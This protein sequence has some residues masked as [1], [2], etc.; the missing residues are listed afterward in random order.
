MVLRGLNPGWHFCP[1]ENRILYSLEHGDINLP[2][3]IRTV[4][5]LQRVAHTLDRNIQTMVNCPSM[6]NSAQLPILDRN[7]W[8]KGNQVE[9]SIY[10]KPMAT[11]YVIKYSSALSLR[12]KRQ[13]LLQEGLRRIRNTGLR[14]KS[15]EK[16]H[17]MSKSHN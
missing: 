10:S 2:A 9:H 7:L 14:V 16:N 4:K 11:Q 5:V 8:I 13:A 12:T 6:N 1:V 15:E 17:I 3:D